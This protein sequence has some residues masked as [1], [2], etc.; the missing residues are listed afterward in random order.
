[1]KPRIAADADAILDRE[2]ARYRPQLERYGVM[3][4][5]LDDEQYV[6]VCI[7]RR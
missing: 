4:G 5:K 7:F 2:L 1:M 3:L 6:W